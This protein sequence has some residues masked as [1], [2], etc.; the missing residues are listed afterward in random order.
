VR[1]HIWACKLQTDTWKSSQ[2][3]GIVHPKMKIHPHVVPGNWLMKH[4]I[5]LRLYIAPTCLHHWL[6]IKKKTHLT[7]KH[8]RRHGRKLSV[9][10]IFGWTIP[11]NSF[12]YLIIIGYILCIFC[13]IHCDCPCHIVPLTIRVKQLPSEFRFF[14]EAENSFHSL[15]LIGF[16]HKQLY[17]R[18]ACIIP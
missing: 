16:S 12:E 9:C 11:K 3:N 2:L 14:W 13:F 17:H 15:W 18:N 4:W 8:T 6:T 5:K 1:V 7:E 10:L